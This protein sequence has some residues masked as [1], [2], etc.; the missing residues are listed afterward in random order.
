MTDIKRENPSVDNWKNISKKQ[1]KLLSLMEEV[2]DK[3]KDFS[4]STKELH[5]HQKH[6]KNQAGHETPSID[7]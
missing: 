7:R 5:Q 2:D 3:R 6:M 1:L 4:S